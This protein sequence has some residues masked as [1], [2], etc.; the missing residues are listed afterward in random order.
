MNCIRREIQAE[1]KIMK[2]ARCE[3]KIFKYDDATLTVCQG[4]PSKNVLI[5]STM[6]PSVTVT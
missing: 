2:E 5:L 6:H 4:K 1:V 3:T